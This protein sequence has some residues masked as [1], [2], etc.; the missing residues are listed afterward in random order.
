V[1]LSCPN[2]PLAISRANLTTSKS[3]RSS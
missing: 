3:T 1:V 2:L